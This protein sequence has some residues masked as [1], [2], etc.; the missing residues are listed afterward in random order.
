MRTNDMATETTTGGKST[1]PAG[2]EVHAFQAEMKQLLQ[3]I[4]HSLYSE[5]EI[6][7]RELISNSSDAINRL[8]FGMQTNADVRDKDAPL[9]ITLGIEKDAK[10]ITV[11]DTGSGMTRDEVVRNLGTIARSGT[12]EFVRNLAN[13]DASQ[14]QNMIGQFGVGFYSVFMVAKRVVVDTCPADP[15]QPG[16]RWVSE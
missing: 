2:G 13:A 10:V 12:L 1:A 11:S 9:E 8:K 7:L 16:T 4:I 14:R 15:A 6:F 3:I 5:R